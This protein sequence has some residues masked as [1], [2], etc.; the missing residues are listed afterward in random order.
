MEIEPF[1]LER[2]FDEHE[3]DAD[4][5][6]AE[7]GIRSLDSSRFDTDPGELGYV[8]PTDGDPE[9]RARVADRYDRSADELCFTCGTQEA[10][11]L[12]VLAT[13]GPDDHA[14]V[15][16]PTY[17]SLYALP[18]AVADVTRVGLTPPA[19]RLDVE[20][21][22]DAI[23]PETRLV[24]LNNPNNPTGRYHSWDRVRA[25]Y[26]I[27]ADSDAYL[28]CDEVYRL[29]A[30]D[31]LPPVAS[32]GEHGISTASLTK[33][34]GLAGL[35]FGWLCGPPEIAAAARRWKDYTTISPSIFGQHVARQA[36]GEQEGTILDENRA[37]AR[38]NHGVV[39]EFVDEHGLDWHDPVGVNGFPT[40]PEGFADA[41]EFCRT[42]VEAESVV[43]APGEVFG[44]DDRFRIGFGLPADELDEGLAR[45]ERVIEARTTG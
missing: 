18:E 4:V 33:A 2:W 24:V 6:L 14:V 43:L 29:L 23:R 38:R 15:V 28:L 16:T 36:L 31:P 34:Y 12:T 41:R 11:L 13:L 40:V 37:H 8:I 22:A 20:R 3:H 30:D 9:F 26:D 17:Q 45:V 10:N 32:L 27:A 5:M 35:R 1:A 39:R 19:W 21:V 7:S 42:V 44:F 25:L